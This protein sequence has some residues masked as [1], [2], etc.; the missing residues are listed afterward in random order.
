M[1]P[2]RL[3][4]QFRVVRVNGKWSLPDTHNN[5]SF[6]YWIQY[7]QTTI[8]NQGCTNRHFYQSLFSAMNTLSRQIFWN[9]SHKNYTYWV[10][11]GVILLSCNTPNHIPTIQLDENAH[12]DDREYDWRYPDNEH[13]C[14]ML[15]ELDDSCALIKATCR[16][17]IAYPQ[18]DLHE[19]HPYMEDVMIEK[20]SLH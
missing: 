15:R 18:W 17:S 13:E 2:R 3:L 10:I 20:D 16:R 9:K 14:I 7:N 1:P 11:I 8:T 6:D 19:T 4:F 5:S 12:Y